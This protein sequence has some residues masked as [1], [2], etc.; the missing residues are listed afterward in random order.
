M[1]K[2]ILRRGISAESGRRLGKV[3][4]T[5]GVVRDCALEMRRG[6]VAKGAK[7]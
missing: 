7:E 6:G 3:G 2:A 1:L 4:D 5:G